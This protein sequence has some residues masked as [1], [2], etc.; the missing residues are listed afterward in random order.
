MLFGTDDVYEYNAEKNSGVYSINVKL[1]LRIR[2]KLGKFKTGKFKPRIQCH[3][4]VPLSSS[5]GRFTSSV[6]TT[7]CKLDRL[8]F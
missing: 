6:V 3:L 4:K 7:K 5:N 8:L 2:F 1:N